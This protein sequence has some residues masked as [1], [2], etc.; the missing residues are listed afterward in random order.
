ML[1]GVLWAGW[2]LPLFF[3]PGAD[4]FGQSFFLYL[5]QVTALSVAMFWLMV[6][7]LWLCAG[8]FIF[9]MRKTAHI[10]RM[11]QVYDSSVRPRER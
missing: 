5:L 4:T 2:H 3:V 1:L 8:H 6:A 7:L 9:R 11:A 10:A